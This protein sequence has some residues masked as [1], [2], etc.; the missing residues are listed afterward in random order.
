[1]AFSVPPALG[2]R[3]HPA[4]VFGF[5]TGSASGSGRTDSGSASG[6]GSGTE[7]G[8]AGS[9]SVSGNA[10]GSVT[11]SGSGGKRSGRESE[12]SGMRR[13]DS[14]ETATGRRSARRRKRSRSPVPRSRQGRPSA[15]WALGWWPRAG[16]GG[17]SPVGHRSCLLPIARCLQSHGRGWEMMCFEEQVP[18][19]PVPC[20]LRWECAPRAPYHHP[21]SGKL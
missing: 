17:G 12:P 3:C 2:A 16:R 13:T 7:S 10:S 15:G 1:M 5:R 6:S 8:S 18:P 4:R 19:R 14:T 21:K 9:G 11:R 20:V